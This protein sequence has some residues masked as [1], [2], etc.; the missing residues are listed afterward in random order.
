M[1][2]H[3]MN[4]LATLPWQVAVPLFFA[5]G[6][7]LGFGYFSALRRTTALLLR[8]GSMLLV[9][10]LTLARMAAITAGFFLAALVGWQALLA[11]FAGAMLGRA[12]I[13]AKNQAAP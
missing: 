1:D 8:Q 10:A 11:A 5:G 9:L 6:F 4:M 7:L 3:A 12:L 2:E 13:V